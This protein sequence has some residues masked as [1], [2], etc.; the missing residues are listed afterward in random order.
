MNIR[1]LILLS[2]MSMTSHVWGVNVS[3]LT[4]FCRSSEQAKLQFCRIYIGSA[5]D[6][7]AVMND[8]AK[9]QHNPLYCVHETAIFNVPKIKA[10]LLTLDGKWHDKNAALP[11]VE[12]LQHV[13]DCPKKGE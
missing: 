8:R 12:Y 3:Q 9:A 5:L 6:A 13:G 7:I 2:G 10:Y 1:V 11:I 4:E